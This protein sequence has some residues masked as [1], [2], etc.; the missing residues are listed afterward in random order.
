TVAPV[1]DVVSVA[2]EQALIVNGHVL[3]NDD[4]LISGA[5]RRFW[6]E[7]DMNFSNIE[8]L[9][10]IDILLT[11]VDARTRDVLHERTYSGHGSVKVSI[12][13]EKKITESLVAAVTN[14]VEDLVMDEDLVE[15]L[16]GSD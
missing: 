11:F 16:G 13:S 14:L 9:S 6:T 12:V 3:G 5:V 2:L 10:Y 7:S 1:T 4:I 15:A 8:L